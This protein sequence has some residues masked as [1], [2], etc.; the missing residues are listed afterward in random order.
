MRRLFDNL[1]ETDIL[2]LLDE[3]DSGDLQRRSLNRSRLLAQS[4]RAAGGPPLLSSY[5]EQALLG[6][7]SHAQQRQQQQRPPFSDGAALVDG[8]SVGMQRLADSMAQ[9]ARRHS[10]DRMRDG[11]FARLAK[12][13][14][15]LWAAGGRPD[16]I[17]VIA[18][19]LSAVPHRGALDANAAVAEGEAVTRFGAVATAVRRSGAAAA[20]AE[21]SGSR[22]PV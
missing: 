21:G 13:N 6:A 10:L 15:I 16:D 19:R 1:D 9:A 14:D 7:L 20:P 12:E 4:G 5:G 22:D 18:A 2:A 8:G 17:T 11:P 3:W